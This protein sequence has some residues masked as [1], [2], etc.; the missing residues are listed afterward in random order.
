[1][2]YNDQPADMILYQGLANRALGREDKARS[3]FFR[4]ISYG[5]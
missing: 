5:E 1:M 3:R 4:L 2:Y